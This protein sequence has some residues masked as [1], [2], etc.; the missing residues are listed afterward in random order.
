M[1]SKTVGVVL[2]LIMAAMMLQ[3]TRSFG[4]A[5]PVGEEPPYLHDR[6]TGM[7][8]SQFGTYVGKGELKIYPFYEYYR[9]NNYEYK[10]AELGYRLD[11]DFR[12]RYRG[13]E[14]LLFLGYGVS[15][16]AAIEFEIATISAKLDKSKDDLSA[17]PTKIEES[18]LGDVEGQI[19]MRWNR[20]NTKKPE[21][22]SY[23][24]AVFPTGKKNSLIGTSDWEFKFGSGLV[25]GFGWGTIT[26]R[27][28][29]DYSAAEK[30]AGPGE[31]AIEYLK[32]V[33][34][35][36][37]F[38]FMLEGTEDEIVLVPEIQLHFGRNVFL[39][40]N[41]GIGVTSKA[42]DFAPEIGVMFSVN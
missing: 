23:F 27:A 41:N 19:R 3:P 14:G 28:A 37:R 1:K 34:N 6:G 10:P 12:G 11:Q 20:E 33:S 40:V 30:S 15:E 29:V 18:G 17:V 31:Y 26:L 8:L 2:M 38:F 22:F 36:F 16:R 13:K 35:H 39:K 24:E 9:D 42:T 7:P 5:M 4:Q 25:K 21:Y 32:R